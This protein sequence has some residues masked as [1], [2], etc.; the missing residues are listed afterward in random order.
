M[1]FLR[2]EVKRMIEKVNKTNMYMPDWSMSTMWGGA[3]LLHMHLR[4]IT[5]LLDRRTVWPWD[6]VLNL[7]ES[8]FPIKTI[9]ELTLY[10]H[11]HR[12]MNFL[13]FFKREYEEYSFYLN[14]FLKYSNKFYNF[15]L[16]QEPRTRVFVYPMRWKDVEDW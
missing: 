3:N 5:E 14:Q 4:V 11:E 1:T 16:L 6:F 7:S 12:R 10:L 8:D 9:Q 13:R 15:K 2:R